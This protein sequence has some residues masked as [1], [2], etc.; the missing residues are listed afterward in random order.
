MEERARRRNHPSGPLNKRPIIVSSAAPYVPL[1]SSVSLFVFAI[2]SAVLVLWCQ[3]APILFA[4]CVYVSVCFSVCHRLVSAKLGTQVCRDTGSSRDG[5]GAS[6][7]RVQGATAM[8]Q[9]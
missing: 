5:H 7:A 2:Q 3:A 6:S 9:Q 8:L 4:L 1:S